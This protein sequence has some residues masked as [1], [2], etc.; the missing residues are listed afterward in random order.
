MPYADPADARK[1]QRRYRA[2]RKGRAVARASSLKYM[3]KVLPGRRALI[4]ALKMHPCVECGVQWPPPAMD[5]DHRPG[6]IKKFNIG[7]Q[8]PASH[9]EEEILTEAAKCDVVC[10]CCHRLRTHERARRARN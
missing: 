10:A 8:G 6:T 7:G 3:R 1:R 5:F 2:T 9:T 4:F